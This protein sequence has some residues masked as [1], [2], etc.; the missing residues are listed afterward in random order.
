MGGTLFPP[1]RFPSSSHL[2]S[3]KGNR[4]RREEG[5]KGGEKEDITESWNEDSKSI[6]I[7]VV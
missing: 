7:L 2:G 3:Y 5:R 4:K 1:C 6:V